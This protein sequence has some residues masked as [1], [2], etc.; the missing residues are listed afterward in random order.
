MIG[1]AVVGLA[2]L[3][4]LSA[5]QPQEPGLT[6]GRVHYDG[7]GDWYA[8]PS[9]LPNLLSAIRERT[10]LP[11]SERE[12]VV[13]LSGPE[14]WE[15]PVLYMTGHGN[16]HFSDDEVSQLRRYLENGGFLHADDNYGMDES[17]RREIARVF[18]ERP[19]V[20]IP[21][22]HEVY[23]I[24]YRFPQGIPKIHEHDGLPGQAFGIF[25][26][27]RL[28]VFYS[29]QS[30]LGDGWEDPEVHA[31]PPEVREAALQMGVNLFVYAVT[32]IR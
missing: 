10:R 29:Y 3:A 31:D 22:E 1:K 23:S 26:A 15:V 14:L 6:V 18:P 12:R 7:G 16:V 32:T 4:L 20:E 11:V 30:D 8:N 13:R 28:A 19:L 27:G 25:V 17:F 2:A 5:A 24:L 21:L 9:S